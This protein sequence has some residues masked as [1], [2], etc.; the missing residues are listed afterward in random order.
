MS[1]TTSK[2]L[3]KKLIFLTFHLSTT[4]NKIESIVDSFI[5]TFAPE[6]KKFDQFS[7]FEY[8]TKINEELTITEWDELDDLVISRLHTD[9]KLYTAVR[10]DERPSLAII[11]ARTIPELQSYAKEYPANEKW[12]E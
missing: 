10:T 11:V 4:M 3:N 7:V 6:Y 5:D 9:F 12:M 1:V 8:E 2:T